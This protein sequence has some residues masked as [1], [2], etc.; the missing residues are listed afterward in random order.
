MPWSD[1]EKEAPQSTTARLLWDDDNLYIIY[2]CVDPYLD[3]EVTAHDGPVYQEDA[4]EIF[5]TPNAAVPG[6]YYGYEMNINGTLL[7]YIAFDGGKERTKAIHPSWQSEG[8]VIATTYDRHPQRPPR[9]PTKAGFSKSPSP[10]TTFATWVDRF[11]RRTATNGAPDSTAPR[12]TKANLGCGPIPARPRPTSTAPP[13]SASSPSRPLS[14]AAEAR[15]SGSCNAGVRSEESRF[16]MVARIRRTSASLKAWAGRLKGWRGK[17][18]RLWLRLLGYY[19]ALGL[20]PVLLVDLIVLNTARETIEEAV[21]DSRR[22]M[23]YRTAEEIARIFSP[24]VSNLKDLAQTVG[25]DPQDL[26]A[27]L[28]KA[29]LASSEVEA[30][31]LVDAQNQIQIASTSLVLPAS[32]DWDATWEQAAAGNLY[33]A[34]IETFKE[35]PKLFVALPVKRD[36]QPPQQS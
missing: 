16:F 33:V 4:V 22:E 34:L 11:R 20:V 18:Q 32:Y 25:T 15:R 9:T 21:L 13:V 19:F 12:A 26:D 7:D 5:A 24:I 28:K 14:S 2:E 30:F 27:L 6:N 31:Y 36:D 17:R 8:V 3:A 23:A 10:T 1:L 29:A 35:T